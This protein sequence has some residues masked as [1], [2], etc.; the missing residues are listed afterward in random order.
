[1]TKQD[2]IAYKFVKWEINPLENLKESTPYI[3]RLKIINGEKLTR[4]EKNFITRE[5]NNNSYSKRGIPLQGWMFIF[6]PV[7]TSYIVKQYGQWQ[8]YNA[9]DKTSLRAILSGKIDKII[10]NA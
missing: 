2:N 7:L 1:M 6:S 5:V 8:E 10:I 9:T 4:E 3:L